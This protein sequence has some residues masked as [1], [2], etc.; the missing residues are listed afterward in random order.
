MGP[1]FGMI[2]GQVIS[3]LDVIHRALK[4]GMELV[5]NRLYILI[6]PIL[7]IAKSIYDFVSTLL[8]KIREKLLSFDIQS[9]TM[10]DGAFGT[11]LDFLAFFN[12]FLPLE[13]L[14]A[15]AVVLLLFWG[16]CLLVRTIKGVKQTVAF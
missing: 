4:K 6:A 12:S 7:A 16:I 13:E 11:G 15:W 9:L 2:F 14:F 10:D 3:S 1:W 8:G 5:L